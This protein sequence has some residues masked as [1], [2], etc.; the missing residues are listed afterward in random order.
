M[1]VVDIAVAGA[2]CCFVAETIEAHRQPRCRS[3]WMKSLGPIFKNLRK[4]PK[5]IL[6]SS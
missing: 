1:D 3:M 4:I 5:I 2:A 6:R